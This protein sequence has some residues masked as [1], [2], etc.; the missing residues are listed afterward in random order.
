MYSI[1]KKKVVTF[2]MMMLVAASVVLILYRHS[3]NET[4]TEAMAETPQTYLKYLQDFHN[5]SFVSNPTEENWER[6][7]KLL[8]VPLE[9]AKSASWLEEVYFLC[10]LSASDEHEHQLKD[11]CPY[12]VSQTEILW[13]LGEMKN[14]ESA[15]I[16]VGIFQ[17]D[18]LSFDGEMLL[19]LGHVITLCGKPCIKYLREVEGE[20][21]ALAK[22]WI[23]YISRGELFGP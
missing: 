18:T 20:R 8:R 12:F 15:S 5:P 21:K 17:D 4:R 22:T 19:N 7:Y 1:S 6:M 11:I 9:S 3:I 10:E 16:L 2:W 13:H 14:E 23:D